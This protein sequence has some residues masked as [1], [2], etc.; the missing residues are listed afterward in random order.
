MSKKS[1]IAISDIHGMYH[2]LE[3]L[4]SKI[5]HEDKQLIFLGDYIDRGFQSKQVIECLQ[6]LQQDHG[7]IILKGNHEDMFVQFMKDPEEHYEW[8]AKNGGHETLCSILPPMA[9]PYSGR[10]GRYLR[11]GDVYT[12]TEIRDRVEEIVPTWVDFFENLPVYHET[13]TEIFVHAG[14]NPRLK[15]WKNDT[16]KTFLWTRDS[17]HDAKNTTGKLIVFGHT[18]YLHFTDTS[19]QI[20]YMWHNEKEKYLGIDGNA[21]QQGGA[22]NAVEIQEGEW[23]THHLQLNIK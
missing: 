4:L 19:H 10:L 18:P 11:L 7:A 5:D 20:G 23:I 3:S 16:E 17:F 1:Y 22:L 21:T 14:I 2:L 8:Y 9:F 6:R 15:N 12:P 13:E